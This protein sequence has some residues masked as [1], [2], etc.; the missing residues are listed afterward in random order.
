MQAAGAFR[1]LLNNKIAPENATGRRRSNIAPI[2][3]PLQSARE[4]VWLFQSDPSSSKAAALWSIIVI[5]AIIAANLFHI[6]ETLPVFSST[7]YDS[8]I[9]FHIAEYT[10]LAIFTVE[11]ILTLLS[12]PKWSCVLDVAFMLDVIVIIPSYMELLLGSTGTVSL[13]MLRIFRLL[14]V[15]RLF[16]VSRSST[17]LVISSVRRSISILCMF[18]ILVFIIVTIAGTVM[19]ILERGVWNSEF[20]EWR[21]ETLWS[22]HYDVATNN[23]ILS[24]DGVEVKH[25]PPSCFLLRSS[26]E[27]AT[28]K[29]EVPIE[30]GYNCTPSQWDVSPFGSIPDAMWWAVVSICTVGELYQ[31]MEAYERSFL[32]RRRKSGI[33]VGRC[34]LSLGCYIHLSRRAAFICTLPMLNKFSFA[35]YG[36]AAPKSFQGRFFGSVVMML[37]ILMIAVPITVIGNNFSEVRLVH[38]KCFDKLKPVAVATKFLRLAGIQADTCRQ[39]RFAKITMA[40]QTKI[41]FDWST[42]QPSVVEAFRIKF[43]NQKS[44][45][46]PE[47][48]N[49]GMHVHCLRVHERNAG[50][51]FD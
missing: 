3:T 39:G 2:L 11:I 27:E 38:R 47:W 34:V 51:M 45:K 40:P 35:G 18:V 41:S 50:Y 14:R 19:H 15:L 48:W 33:R 46:T 37:G 7:L 4:C 17:A 32:H 16:R 12:A 6:I 36:D 1:G 24:V 26:G 29:C 5:L 9:I 10:T 13:S 42:W 31:F 21:R 43:L 8:N 25:V 20:G 28:F 23:D 30:T 22:C 49:G 44:L